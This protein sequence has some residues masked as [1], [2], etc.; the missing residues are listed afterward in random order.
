MLP[1]SSTSE[2]TERLR[3]RGLRVTPQRQRI[4]Q[5]LSDSTTHPTAEAVYAEVRRDMPTISLKT[6]YETLKELAELGEIQSFDLGLGARRF[7]PNL[8]PHHHL[9]CDNCG[10]VSDVAADFS[11]VEIP[12]EQCQGFTVRTI[13]V[14]FRGICEQCAQSGA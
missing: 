6:V 12:S 4:F 1:V 5:I 9:I 11:Q 14:S 8:E 13:E 10:R 7:D 2:L 3:R